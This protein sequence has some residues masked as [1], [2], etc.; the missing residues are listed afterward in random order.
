MTKMGFPVGSC[1][2]LWRSKEPQL[3][4]KAKRGNRHSRRS[5]ANENQKQTLVVEELTGRAVPTHRGLH[6]FYSTLCPMLEWIGSGA[7]MI[8]W[9]QLC[10]NI[11]RWYYLLAPSST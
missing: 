4:D 9:D 5:L 8:E 7:S 2:A 11:A 1:A 3:A 6:V 10:I